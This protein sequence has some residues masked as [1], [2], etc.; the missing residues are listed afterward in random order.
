MPIRSP[1]YLRLGLWLPLENGVNIVTGIIALENLIT[2]N[3][4]G[5]PILFFITWLSRRAQS[6]RRNF[7]RRV[8]FTVLHT[9]LFIVFLFIDSFILDIKDVLLSS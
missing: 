4:H 8:W 6:G 7:V 3:G 5:V 9:V 1:T 2:L